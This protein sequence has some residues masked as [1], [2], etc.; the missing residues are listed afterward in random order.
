MCTGLEIALIAG[1]AVSA[2]GAISQGQQAKKMG[3][4][5]QEQAAAD[6]QAEREAGQVRA[7]KLRKM[8][9]LQKSEARAALSKSGV[10]ADAG[11]ALEI[12][13]DITMRSEE[14]ALSE[15]LTGTRRSSRLNQEGELSSRA[16]DNAYT[17]GILGAGKS[18]LSGAASYQALKQPGW[19]A[20]QPPAPVESRT[21]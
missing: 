3:Q 18:V 10:V 17:A 5:Q 8:G 9:R 7:D 15:I 19:K 6:A 1:T 21:W 2:V 14:D 4:F 20:Q 16:G 11:S 12:Q 13:S